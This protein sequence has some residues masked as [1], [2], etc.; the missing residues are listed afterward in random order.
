MQRSD[1][2]SDRT[3]T[4]TIAA[5]SGRKA[6]YAQLH[7]L[8]R[9]L[10]VA[11]GRKRLAWLTVAIVLTV[12]ANAVAQIRLNRWQGAFYD[13]LEQ[14][15]LDALGQ[16]LLVFLAVV[17]VLLVLGVSET[18]LREVITV[19]LREWLTRDLLGEWLAPKR[20]Y[21]LGFAGAIGVNPDQ[22]MQEDTR[23]LTELSADLATGL[24]RSV[25][26]LVSFIGVLWLLSSQVVF[27]VAQTSFGIPGY[28]VWCA[29][30][31]AVGGSLLTWRV[32]HPL[33]ALNAERYAREAEMRFQ[34]VRVS[35]S[36]EGIAMYAGERDEKAIVGGA[37]ENVVAVTLSLAN[38]LA[39][40]TWVTGGYGWLALVVPIVVAAPGYFQGSLSFGGLMMVV[41]AF[42]QVQTA[43]RWFVDSFARIADWRAALLRVAIYRDA[44]RDLEEQDPEV[45]RI[46]RTENDVDE[47]MID[48]LGVHLADGH[49]AL[50]ARQ[51]TVK[52]GEHVLV[53]GEPGSGKSTLFRAMA[54]LWPWGTGTIRLPASASIMFLPQRP[55]LPV[56]TLHATLA[57][58]DALDGFDA[59]AM[60]SALARVG[61]AH[62]AA[63]LEQDK[64]WDKQLSLDEQ[65]RLAF[66]RLLLHAPRFVF[67]DD[68]TSA[69]DDEHKQ[70]LVSILSD[71]LRGS[72][73]INVSRESARSDFYDRTLRLRRVPKT[74]SLR[75]APAEGV[76]AD[77]LEPLA[78]ELGKA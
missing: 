24:L 13:A 7:S 56:G 4:D 8:G 49:T 55:Y 14:R 36:A 60:R 73:V 68:V 78:V 58:P 2:Q 46:E 10:R 33:I 30:I 20:A 67:L 50:D 29:L 28:L 77:L 35:E 21:L 63:S 38:G 57:Y 44:L 3:V 40:L 75:F 37:L 59:S 27:T 39:R 70:L 23:R 42:S 9:A 19:R 72:A 47:L 74:S 51:V 6:V 45:N 5:R 11:P 48:T 34:M 66:A 52:P 43:L 25:L 62:L 76:P 41:G 54:G 15:Q 17:S 53:V 16:Q 61:L 69:L 12:C 65:Q 26:L 71:E 64:R 18:W 1:S 32:G 31:Y 22:R